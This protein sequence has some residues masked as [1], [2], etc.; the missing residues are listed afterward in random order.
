MELKYRNSTLSSLEMLGL[1]R[2]FMEL[3][4]GHSSSGRI[5]RM[6]KSHLYGIEIK[7]V[8]VSMVLQLTV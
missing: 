5:S 6:F 2:T 1:N 7:L 4:S 3:K 8:F